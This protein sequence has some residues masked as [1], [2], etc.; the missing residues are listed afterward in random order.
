V[1]KSGGGLR[2]PNTRPGRLDRRPV[3][4]R[5]V[6]T[7]VFIVATHVNSLLAAKASAR[8]VD[9]VLR[10]DA[11]ALAMDRVLRRAL[12]KALE[13]TRLGYSTP[14]LWSSSL[15]LFGAM[16]LDL[17]REIS[18]TLERITLFAYH[19]A[20]AG[21]RK[22]LPKGYLKVAVI[23]AEG[24]EREEILELLF[25][26]LD[27]PFIHSIIY[28]T[29][30]RERLQAS[31]RLATPSA[32]ASLLAAG[33][34]AGKSQA[35]IARDL[36]PLVDGVRS[37]ARR[38]ART[39]AIRVAGEGQLAAHERLG[40]DLVIGYQ[41]RAT[42]DQHTRPHHAARSGTVYYRNPRPGQLGFDK[43]PRPPI[44]EDGKTVAFN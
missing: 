31:T 42:L 41:V 14:A 19:S 26:P 7:K 22:V 39:E 8:Q 33:V 38:I 37:S 25:P 23:E 18:H 1:K 36:L 34:A 12:R 4:G 3:V 9:V 6:P 21:V 43:M 29:D 32:L 2:R 24:E 44:E 40:P 5:V 15:T 27:V 28:A 11:A 13:R 17:Q 16:L 20:K 35:E 10:A 30:W